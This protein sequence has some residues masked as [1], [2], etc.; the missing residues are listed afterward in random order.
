MSIYHPYL[1]SYTQIP[2][3]VFLLPGNSAI[4]F[5]KHI[6]QLPFNVLINILTPNPS[7]QNFV[8]PEA[9]RK[10]EISTAIN[11]LQAKAIECVAYNRRER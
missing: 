3:S 11:T 7:E 2:F 8:Q 1:A 9:N 5:H 10:S 6:G 4:S